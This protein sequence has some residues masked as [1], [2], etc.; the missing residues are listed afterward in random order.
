MN[1]SYS[2]SVVKALK[3]AK[4][5]SKEIIKEI[6]KTEPKHCDVEKLAKDLTATIVDKVFLTPDIVEMIVH[7]PL[8]VQNFKAGQFFKLQNFEKTASLKETPFPFILEPLALTGATV[9]L[10]KGLI[11]LIVL[12]SGLSSSL[13]CELDIGEEIALLGPTGEPTEI[14][15]DKNVLLIGGGVGNA[16]L[17]SIG[18]E[19]KAN[20][21]CVHYIAGY[22]TKG[23]RFKMEEIEASSDYV[24]W[25][26]EEEVLEKNRISDFSFKGNVI[27]VLEIIKDRLEDI[28]HII[29]IGSDKMMKAVAKARFLTF[30]DDFLKDPKLIGSINS[31]MQCMMK[32]ICGQCVQVHK[33][34]ETEEE[35]IV[36]SCQNQDQ[37]LKTLDFNCLH[38]R[39]S[40][41]SLQEKITRFLFDHQKKKA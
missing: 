22:K 10:K 33:C 25:V 17:F 16:V 24:Y 32:G 39:L 27:D 4:D 23:S 36:F 37:D 29:A 34:D 31:P 26:C 11:S 19:L 9:D 40:Q 6:K 20:N 28:D 5:G 14:V 1:K 13:A 8:H 15:K 3:S 18:K 30:R 7:A 41:N 21:C 12:K 2:G 35:K 38:D